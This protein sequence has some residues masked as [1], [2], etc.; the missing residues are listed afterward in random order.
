MSVCPQVHAYEGEI[1]RKEARKERERVNV[2]VL[3]ETTGFGCD[4]LSYAWVIM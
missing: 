4:L 3:G 1:R 2:C